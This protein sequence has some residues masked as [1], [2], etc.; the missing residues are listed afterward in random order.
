M[1]VDL[2]Y[3]HNL[4]GF[5]LLVPLE[6]IRDLICIYS[7]LCGF[8]APC[9]AGACVCVDL[10]YVHNLCGFVLL[11]PLEPIRELTCIY[12]LLCGLCAPC[13]AGAYVCVDL[14]CELRAAGPT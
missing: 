1:C 12:S 5:V 2:L 10:L 8:C 7:L 3:V 9:A 6:P 11:V 13:A 14:L 4:C